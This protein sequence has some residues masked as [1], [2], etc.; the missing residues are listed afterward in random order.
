MAT[1]SATFEDPHFGKSEMGS[2][3]WGRTFLQK[4]PKSFKK[5]QK[6]PMTFGPFSKS[7][8]NEPNITIAIPDAPLRSAISILVVIF[9]S[10]VADFENGPNVIG[11]FW[12]FLKL[13][14]TFCKKVWPHLANSNCGNRP[15]GRRIQV[16][17]SIISV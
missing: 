5:C 9:G 11:T 12:P 2:N 10:F 4:V 3:R 8:T 15:T 7:A 1:Q 14:G 17:Y 16:C 13:L 6:V